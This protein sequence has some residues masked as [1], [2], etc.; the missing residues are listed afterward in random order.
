MKIDKNIRFSLYLS[1]APFIVLLLSILLLIV[2]INLMLPRP[3]LFLYSV[4]VFLLLVALFLTSLVYSLVCL[5]ANWRQYKIKATLPLLA[6]RVIEWIKMA[7]FK[8]P[9]TYKLIFSALN[10]LRLSSRKTCVESL[11]FCC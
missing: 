7:Q 3:D 1:L 10:T 2:L 8:V 11:V 5:F 6:L 4:F 9:P